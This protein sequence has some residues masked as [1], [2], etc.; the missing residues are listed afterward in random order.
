MYASGLWDIA[1]LRKSKPGVDFR[2]A[3]M[4]L[5]MTGAT[6]GSTVGGSSLFV[7]KGS[8]QRKLAF[9][10]MTHLTSDRYAL[11]FAQEQ[12]R[13]PVRSR[14]YTDRFFED[15][16]LQ[17]VVGQL[18]TARPER[19]DSFP[20]AGKALATAIDQ[21]LLNRRDPATALRE[22]RIQAELALGIS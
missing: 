3:P 21:I 15:P 2:A 10:F 1:K 18:R 16:V 19:V 20:D 12:G 8:N 9:D 22:A 5:G 14:V 13:L 4:P 17:V 11:R 7:P 6:E